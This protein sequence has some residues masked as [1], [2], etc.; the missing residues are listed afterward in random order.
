MLFRLCQEKITRKGYYTVWI[1]LSAGA[2]NQYFNN[3]EKGGGVEI[4]LG[5]IRSQQDLMELIDLHPFQKEYLHI[6]ENK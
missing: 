3:N 6:I 2:N 5:E 4:D 1:E